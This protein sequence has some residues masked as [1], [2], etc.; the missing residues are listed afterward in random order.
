MKK[1]LIVLSV[2]LL[3]AASALYAEHRGVF[4][5]PDGPLQG[6]TRNTAAGTVIDP[7]S[8]LNFIVDTGINL[9]RGPDRCHDYAQ[10][11][12]KSVYQLKGIDGKGGS[13]KTNFIAVT[14]THPTQAVTIHVRYYN[15]ACYDLLDFLV[16]LTCNDTLIFNPFDF[17]IPGQSLGGQ[18]I[19]TG[20]I[21]FGPSPAPSLIP[22]IAGSDFRSGR[23][24]IQLT[25]AGTSTDEDDAAELLFSY[26]Q[27]NPKIGKTDDCE[28]IIDATVGDKPGVDKTNL[29][30]F[31]AAA[32]SFNYLV[33]H[34]TVAV[35][36][37]FVKDAPQGEDLFLSYSVNAWGRPAVDLTQDLAF[38]NLDGEPDGD[39]PTPDT[40][41]D[42]DTTIR[43][44]RILTGNENVRQ[45]DRVN[46][47]SSNMLYLRN[48]VHAGDSRM[49]L[50][51]DVNG[52]WYAQSFWGALGW[53]SVHPGAYQATNLL[54]V[55]DDYDGSE[56][57]AAIKDFS[58]NA[59]RAETFYVV[60]IYD[61]K[62]EL[63]DLPPGSQ[64]G[65]S[66]LPPTSQGAN[67]SVIVD[68]LRTWISQRDDL[69]LEQTMA[70]ESTFEV[71]DLSID[72]IGHIDETGAI[73]NGNAEMNPDFA[74]L[75]RMPSVNEA[76]TDA[77]NGWIRFVRNNNDREDL[78]GD[79][80]TS[81]IPDQDRGSEDRGS[82]LT[83][84]MNILDYDSF[85]ASWWMPTVAF[86]P[87]VSD[88]GD[89]TP[90]D[91]D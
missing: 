28:N 66:P 21:I 27:G 91:Q 36:R 34:H 69:T 90:Y 14:N 58:Y 81:E 32:I 59:D 2:V 50:R 30:P 3:L 86:D 67:L 40:T 42:D 9:L 65:I 38:R 19:N 12:S 23:F 61:Y 79:G 49:D 17:N 85:G 44:P 1:L 15:D 13:I 41:S 76:R 16:L 87:A 11:I 63:F 55:V 25:A 80:G 70:G 43:L 83:I 46:T 5:L 89:P 84:G 31:N 53:T 57:P 54:S 52:D 68:C 78:K 37:G 29:H 18:P 62:E 48:D 51:P 82:F 56:N 60:Q 4:M 75:A 22:S 39:G 73:M 47:I 20:S 24:Y 45:S 71:D 8:Q 10:L 64:I 77:S 6:Q 7:A 88:T 26:E 72:D 35:P 74:G 33:G